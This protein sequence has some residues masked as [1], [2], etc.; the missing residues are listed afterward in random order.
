MKKK[1]LLF[2]M[3]TL[4]ILFVQTSHAQTTK[5][6][7]TSGDYTTLK[8]AFDDINAGFITGD[9]IIQI[10][11]SITETASAVLNASGSGSASY[12]S[13][14]IYPTTTG[15]TISGYLAFPLIDLN[16]ADNITIDGRVNATGTTKD[17]TITNTRAYSNTTIQFENSAENNTVKYCTVK[18]ASNSTQRGVIFFYSASSGNGNSGN[19]IDNCNITNDG[20]NRP[21]NVI[22][23]I[24]SSG[25]ENRNNTISNNNIYD[26]FNAGAYSY[27]IY[28]GSSS[29]D[30]TITGNSFFETSSPF[31]PTGSYGYYC[32]LI[33]NTTGNNFTITGNYIG[34][35]DALC[36]GTLTVSAAYAHLFYGIYLQVGITTPT[37]VQNNTIKNFNYT[38]TSTTPWY[39]IFS[40]AGNVNIGTTI[41]NTIGSTTGTGSIT[42]T[43]SF[44]N[45]TSYGIS[46]NASGITMNIENN[47]IGS[48]TTVGSSS[49]SH[50]FFAIYRPDFNG[51]IT[52]RNNL[53]GST[54]IANSIQASSASTS[55]TAQNVI[56]VRCGNSSSG[57]ATISG[58]TIANLYNA[59]ACTSATDGAV[60][61]V[62][63]TS[64]VNT[65]QNNTIHDLSTTSPSTNITN[66][67]SVIGISQRSTSSDQ[68]VSANIIYNLSNKYNS[69]NSV[70]VTGLYCDGPTTGTNTVSKN[71]IHSLSLASTSSSSI[72]F[73]IRINAGYTTYSNN[74]INLG[75][76]ISTGYA[77][78]GIY[79]KGAAGNNNNLYFNTVYIGGTPSGTTSSTYALYNA[80]NTNSRNFRNNI[81]NNTRSGGTTGKHYAV[82]LAGKTNLTIDYNDYVTTGG[83][84]LGRIASTD[85]TIL[86][87]TWRTASGGDGNSLN[88]NPT[89]YN[90]GGTTATDYI[91]SV[92]LPGVAGTG[93]TTDYYGTTR[94]VNTMGAWEESI[95]WTGATSTDWSVASNWSS[96]A[97]PLSADYVYISSVPS[98]Q[99]H[100]TASPDSPATCNNL[101]IDPGAILTIDAGK[102]LTVSGTLTNEAGNTGLV[103]ESEASATGSL[104]HST[105][106]VK[107]TVERYVAGWSVNHGWHFLSC[108]MVTEAIQPHFVPD[109][110]GSN[111]DFFKWDEPSNV[112]VNTKTVAGIWNSS[113]ESGFVSGRGYLVAYS[114]DVTKIFRDSINVTDISVSGLTNTNS[115]TYRGWHLLGNP[116]ASAIKWGQGSW[117]KTNIGA[118]PQ[119]WDETTASYKVLA[120]DG[121]ISAMSGFMVYTTGSGSLTIPADA[122]LHSDSVWYKSGKEDRILLVAGDPQGNTAQES[123]I[124]F[125]SGASENF[126]LDYDSYFIA[127]FAPNFYSVA[128]DKNF[129]LNT[130]PVLTEGLS[131]PFGFVKNASSGFNIKLQETMEG[132]T[133]YLTDL[134]TNI[135]QNLNK[136]PVYTFTAEEGDLP[137]RFKLTFGSVGIKEPSVSP[138]SIYTGNGIIYV[139]NN[140]NQTVNG[141]IIVYLITGQIIAT[142]KFTGDRLQKIDFNGKPG[143]YVVKITTDKGVYTQKIIL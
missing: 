35:S 11:S 77:I 59:Y 130:L 23:S 88:T 138:F 121:I 67:V 90:A 60:V 73:G 134:K 86:D 2:I 3:A 142:R 128:G 85:Y 106:N 34:G 63:T 108:P 51:T 30:W 89:F 83:A 5:T 14:N 93:I 22:N 15:Y 12:T 118:N 17:L 19:T 137:N 75:G 101:A 141:T 123:I 71:F 99:P 139:N 132:I 20:D 52:I 127:G 9:I 33:S 120:G 26:F 28:I 103:V 58:N 18:G 47:N 62:I 91:P 102:A 49:Y 98:N 64:G 27:G 136:S 37:S 1:L 44:A 8:A 68:T 126:D 104:I 92:A 21:Y 79:E 116:F 87:A 107:A 113:F 97:V 96:N 32:I 69:S 94:N 41:G 81:L 42:V 74:I 95:S 110:P 122:R 109:P 65:I 24:G 131:I 115:N 129:A 66:N 39:G 13:V 56:G 105:A 84:F 70:C 133:I 46:V 50:S 10:I 43:N 25:F 54:S 140:G 55:T 53:I 36:G 143:C 4:A 57:T 38:S 16:G 78:Y 117:N 100:V 29:T 61:G 7:G 125:N 114:S 112:W 82:Y 119:I 31:T 45:A 111:Q 48:V 124:R 40:N 80:T 76:S 135:T 6:V 72:I